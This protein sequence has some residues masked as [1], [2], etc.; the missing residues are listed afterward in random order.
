MLGKYAQREDFFSPI[1]E[2]NGLKIGMEICHDHDKKK[3]VSEG[4]TKIGELDV[5][6]ISSLGV[7]YAYTAALDKGYRVQVDAREDSSN[8]G[9]SIHSCY[10]SVLN[11]PETQGF[12]STSKIISVP[13][14]QET[15]GKAKELEL[16]AKQESQA[17][18]EKANAKWQDSTKQDEEDMF[19]GFNFDNS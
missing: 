14:N 6:I 16:Q 17:S 7:G 11:K 15:L 3:L 4:H 10:D 19:N 5:H 13:V 9:I 12:F 2:I 8:A 18:K 1:V